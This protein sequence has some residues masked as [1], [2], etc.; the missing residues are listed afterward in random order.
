[1]STKKTIRR[2]EFMAASAGLAVAGLAA[3]QRATA[4][5]AKLAIDG[6]AKAVTATSTAPPRFGA[7]ELERLTEMIKQ[8]ALFYWKGPQ[9]A[10]FK[11]RFQA[12]CPLEH[13]MTCTSGTAA[14]HIAVAATGLVP[15]DEVITSPITDV[16]TVIGIIYQQGVPV[17]ADLGANT[18]TLDPADVERRITPRTKAIIAVHLAGNPS[19]MTELRAI[20]D[21]HG[22]VLIEDACQAWGAKYRGKP[23]G[24]LGDIACWSLQNSKHIT[25]GD[26]GVVASSHPVLGPKL[27][28]FGDKGFNRSEGKWQGF[29]TNYRMSEPQAAVLAGQMTRLE[30]IASSRA[31]LGNLLNAEISGIP[32]ITP[33]EV[34]AEDRCVYWF[35]MFRIDPA[36]FTVDRGQIYK[37]L[38]AEGVP[39][40]P[41]YIPVPVHRSDVFKNH[42]FFNGHWTIK[43]AGMTDMDYTKVETPEAEA[44]LKTGMR[45]FIKEYMT[46]EQIRQFAAGIRKV[47]THY[48]A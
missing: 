25:T 17:F 18:L 14:L 46:E 21:K 19:K 9:T 11:E 1:M 12:M 43:E 35:N 4:A 38:R 22:L 48:K 23:I 16:G 7:P 15:G 40:S 37:A 26:G 34:H 41:G 29:S 2:R 13:V 31:K 3:S 36:A 32:G 39:C 42:A 45:V 30:G 6:G 24:T 5:T 8:D 44:I 28:P 47:A 33:H 27:Q 10:I 20:A